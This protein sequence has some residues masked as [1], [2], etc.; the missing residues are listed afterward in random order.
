MPWEELKSWTAGTPEGTRRGIQ[1]DTEGS[2]V[3]ETQEQTETTLVKLHAAATSGS[4]VNNYMV[5]TLVLW[6]FIRIIMSDVMLPSRLLANQTYCHVHG[7]VLWHLAFICQ[8][9]YMF[10]GVYIHVPLIRSEG[11][12]PEWSTFLVIKANA[13]SQPTSSVR[14]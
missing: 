12:P 11:L 1:S 4:T 8:I 13:I 9:R 3:T 14:K 6:W 7:R 2:R 5:K 10:V